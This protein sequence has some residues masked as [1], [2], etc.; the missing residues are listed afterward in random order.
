MSTQV[1]ERLSRVQAGTRRAARLPFGLSPA[2]VIVACLTLVGFTLVVVYYFSYLRPEQDR[3]ARIDEQYKKLQTDLKPPAV[4]APPGAKPVDSAKVAIDSLEEFKGQSLKPVTQTKI[5]L[6]DEINALAKKNKLILTSG[7]EL[8]EQGMNEA[9][10][11]REESSGKDQNSLDTFPKLAG[12]FTVAGEYTNLRQFIKDL[13]G[14]KH[15]VIVNGVNLTT[16]EGKTRDE[17]GPRVAQI[18][19]IMLTIDFTVPV[20]PVE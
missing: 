12:H 8:A 7:I 2:E 19:G 11:Q 18:S 15:F 4:G 1:R 16:Q 3:L 20:R 9:D 10:R 14:S 13:E 6:F 17:E 5:A